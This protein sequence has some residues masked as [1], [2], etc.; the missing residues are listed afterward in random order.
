MY[1]SLN[2]KDNFFFVLHTKY[3]LLPVENELNLI[4]DFTKVFNFD[5]LFNGKNPIFKSHSQC[6]KT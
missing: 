3:T 4:P 5:F 2:S 6:L 1:N